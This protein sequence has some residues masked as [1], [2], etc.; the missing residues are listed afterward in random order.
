M[1]LSL[2]F[3]EKIKAEFSPTGYSYDLNL[4]LGPQL[5]RQH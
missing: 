3:R 4:C 5:K 2:K 1:T